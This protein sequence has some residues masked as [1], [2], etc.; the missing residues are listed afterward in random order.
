M[1][2]KILTEGSKFFIIATYSICFIFFLLH[3]SEYEA[4]RYL[5]VLEFTILGDSLFICHFIKYRMHNLS[6]L[7]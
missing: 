1:N 2:S 7:S 6:Y 5:S 3:F 4:I